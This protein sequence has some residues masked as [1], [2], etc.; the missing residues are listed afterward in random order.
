MKK[1][2]H[3]LHKNN[4][5][6]ES[7]KIATSQNFDSMGEFLLQDTNS[8]LKKVACASHFKIKVVNNDS[9]NRMSRQTYVA[10]AFQCQFILLTK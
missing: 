8:F 4:K 9:R 6:I 10:N 7:L 1:F 3:S 2:V 5:S